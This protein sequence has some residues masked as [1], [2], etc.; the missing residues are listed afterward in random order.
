MAVVTGVGFALLYLRTG[1]LLALI[2]LHITVDIVGLVLIPPPGRVN[3]PT[4]AEA[5]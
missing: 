5:S 4:P 1:S 3:E 2:G